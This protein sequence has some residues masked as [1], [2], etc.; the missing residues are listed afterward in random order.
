MSQVYQNNN[1]KS[2][3]GS[4]TYKCMRLETYFAFHTTFK[5]ML[6]MKRKALNLSMIKVIK[7]F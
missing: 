3:L 1:C 2:Q 5:T 6:M 7:E 4:H